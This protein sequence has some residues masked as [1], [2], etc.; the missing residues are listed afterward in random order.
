MKRNMII[1]VLPVNKMYLL[2]NAIIEYY[3]FANYIHNIYST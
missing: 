3:K 2:I 1:T